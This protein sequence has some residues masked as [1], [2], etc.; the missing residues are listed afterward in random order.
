[1][2][3]AIY[4]DICVKVLQQRDRITSPTSIPVHSR[5]FLPANEKGK[6]KGRIEVERSET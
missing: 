4:P 3:R 6:R 1:M 2:P 5:Y